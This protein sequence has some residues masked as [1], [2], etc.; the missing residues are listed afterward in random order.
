MKRLKDKD[1]LS[2]GSTG[3]PGCH[4][5]RSGLARTASPPGTRRPLGSA[6]VVAVVLP[7]ASLSLAAPATASTQGGADVTANFTV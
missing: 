3:E 6:T 4:D 2:S 1:V 5:A 7:A